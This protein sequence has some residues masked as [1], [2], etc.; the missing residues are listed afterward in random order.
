MLSILKG[1]RFHMQG[2]KK[3]GTDQGCKLVTYRLQVKCPKPLDH[4]SQYKPSAVFKC[5]MVSNDSLQNNFIVVPFPPPVSALIE[6][7][8]NSFLII[9]LPLL[10]PLL[11]VVSLTACHS[12]FWRLGSCRPF[13]LLVTQN[14]R[15]DKDES[16]TG[17]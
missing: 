16:K 11:M 3:K 7:A 1:V 15:K 4:L 6:L 9:S 8:L 5:L 13:S 17:E 12:D 10:F 14:Q 2:K